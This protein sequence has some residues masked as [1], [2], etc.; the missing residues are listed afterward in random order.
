[1]NKNFR[2]FTTCASVLIFLLGGYDLIVNQFIPSNIR[3]QYLL[4]SLGWSWHT[5]AIFILLLLLATFIVGNLLNEKKE[6]NDSE[7]QNTIQAKD[8]QVNIADRDMIFNGFVSQQRDTITYNNINNSNNTY[9]T[10][11]IN[12]KKEETHQ[13]VSNVDK[14]KAPMRRDLAYRIGLRIQEFEKEFHS[15]TNG[16]PA[17]IKRTY[18]I[19]RTTMN[20]ILDIWL[21]QA[22]IIL[23]SAN[24]IR[25]LILEL[26]KCLNIYGMNLQAHLQQNMMIDRMYTSQNI[27]NEMAERAVY[28]WGGKEDSLDTQISALIKQL[29]DLLNNEAI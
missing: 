17:E 23:S 14:A 4:V 8:S 26:N 1:M 7:K 16:T 15:I 11:N 6:P 2:L 9:N 3:D 10:Y 19:A 27:V 25:A 24:E 29:V 5:W 22:N 20:E 18:T 12:S 28:L 21:P 13:V